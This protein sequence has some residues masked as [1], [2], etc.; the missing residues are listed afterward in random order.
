MPYLL[1]APTITLEGLDTLHA[2]AKRRLEDAAVEMSL[3]AT[4]AVVAGPAADVIVE[5]AESIHAELIAVGTH[6]RSGL[7]RLTL[8]ST[9]AAVIESAPCSVLIVR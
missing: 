5:Y 6:G 4:T 2:L 7:A 9:A 1:S 3:S 8:G